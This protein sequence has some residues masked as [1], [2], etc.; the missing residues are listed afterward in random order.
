MGGQLMETFNGENAELSTASSARAGAKD[1]Q[2][3]AKR[4]DVLRPAVAEWIPNPVVN[5]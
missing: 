3:T 2:L 5:I 4:K 1:F